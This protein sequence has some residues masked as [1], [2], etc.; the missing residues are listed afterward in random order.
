MIQYVSAIVRPIVITAT[1]PVINPVA[2]FKQSAKGTA[3][4]AG[5]VTIASEHGTVI[6]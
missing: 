3:T 2:S 6:L 4:A 1:C 5:S